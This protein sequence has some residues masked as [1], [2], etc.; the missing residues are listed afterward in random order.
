M[1]S[2]SHRN[3]DAQYSNKLHDTTFYKYI[4]NRSSHSNR[5][6]VVLFALFNLFLIIPD[7]INVSSVSSRI[8]IVIFRV[9]FSLS[10][11]LF[12]MMLPRIR[13]FKRYSIILSSLELTGVIL[14]LFIIVLYDNPHYLIQSLGYIAIIIGIFLIPNKWVYML[15]VAIISFLGYLIITLIFIPEVVINERLA[16][17]VYIIITGL[18]CSIGAR[19]TEKFRLREY[20]HIEDLLVVSST[21]PLTKASNR[22]RL[23]KE[24]NRL[25]RKCQQKNLPLCLVFI[26]IDNMK[27]INDKYGHLIGDQVL[28][29]VVERIRRFLST[30]DLIARWGGD[31]FIV[32][33]PETD[34]ANAVQIAEK[35]RNHI[36]NDCFSGGIQI[37]CSFGV[38]SMHANSTFSS[39]IYD[40][41]QR[42]YEGKKKGKNRVEYDPSVAQ[43]TNRP[44]SHS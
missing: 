11:L 25:V 8:A 42:M 36:T 16:G 27:T 29:E 30:K 3:Q 1:Q 17:V 21:D 13:H 6:I 43:T 39:L 19:G 41:D 14:F 32:V 38:A 26:D 9:I 2:S 33:L 4:L 5:N 15:G 10:L 44:Q 12:L 7:M 35:I 22:L 23:E 37:S 40:A 20:Q 24:G 18:L 34:T 31:E 28:I